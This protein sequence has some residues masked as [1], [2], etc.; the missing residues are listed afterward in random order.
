MPSIMRRATARTNARRSFAWASLACA[1]RASGEQSC[2]PRG[3]SIDRRSGAELGDADTISNAPCRVFIPPA[4]ETIE[5]MYEFE[6]DF[7][8]DHSAY[9]AV[10]GDHATPLHDSL[11]TTVNWWREHAK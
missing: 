2:L 3:C 1:E 8:V 11:T 9:A 5:M 7:V 4:R 10:F 6:E